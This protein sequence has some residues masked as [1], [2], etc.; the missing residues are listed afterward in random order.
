M[1][2]YMDLVPNNCPKGMNGVYNAVVIDDMLK[3]GS[4][5]IKIKKTKKGNLI[6]THLTNI[7]TILY[8]MYQNIKD[9]KNGIIK[10][11][12]F[13]Y[14]EELEDKI[15]IFNFDENNEKVLGLVDLTRICEECTNLMDV[16]SK[17]KD[18][19]GNP[20]AFICPKTEDN[21]VLWLDCMD[22]KSKECK[23]K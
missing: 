11:P 7:K 19:S 8:E 23:E 4:H 5:F 6:A 12:I 21:L 2:N 17:I 1:E 3:S 20:L 10:N 14:N 18:K 15:G 16:F 22:C 13:V 9:A